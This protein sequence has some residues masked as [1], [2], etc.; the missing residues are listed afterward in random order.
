M[1]TITPTLA[2]SLEEINKEI[3][4]S[5]TSIIITNKNLFPAI[6]KRFKHI[7]L[8]N[9]I[10]KASKITGFSML[11]LTVLSAE[12]TIP[13]GLTL[14]GT[15]FLLSRIPG[16]VKQAGQY[17]VLDLSQKS[18]TE[19]FLVLLKVKGQN[20]FNENNDVLDLENFKAPLSEN[21]NEV[22][23]EDSI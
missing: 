6:K 4:N 7:K 22:H 14:A 2:T 10:S 5:T 11:A 9:K 8:D 21:N 23:N 20:S 16:F 1:A 12:I 15:S 18:D 19:D 3:V 13:V 17:K